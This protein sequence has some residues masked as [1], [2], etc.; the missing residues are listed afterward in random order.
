MK[1]RIISLISITS[2][3]IAIG[4]M[5]STSSYAAEKLGNSSSQRPTQPITNI[6]PPLDSGGSVP[7]SVGQQICSVTQYITGWVDVLEVVGKVN[8]WV[9]VAVY[10]STIIC[11]IVYR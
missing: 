2:I 9:K 4:V 11:T 3:L 10:G 1:N 8:K 6:L 5:T 7:P